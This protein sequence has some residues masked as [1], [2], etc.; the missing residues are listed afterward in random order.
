MWLV[1]LA[2]LEEM[3]VQPPQ[4][5][6]LPVRCW[7]SYPVMVAL[8]GLVQLRVT[9]VAPP[10]ALRPVGA[11]GL[12]TGVIAVLAVAVPFTVPATARTWK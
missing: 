1:V 11:A 9:S 10:V 3:A 8:F 7:Y 4:V 12:A 6:K 5:P 2:L